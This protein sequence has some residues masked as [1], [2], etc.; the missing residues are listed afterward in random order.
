MTYSYRTLTRGDDEF[1]DA[2][3]TYWNDE[4]VEA[5]KPFNVKKFGFDRIDSE[6]KY[7]ALL[8]QL[9]QV[10][11]GAGICVAGA[12]IL[13]VASGSCWLEAKWLRSEA[14]QKLVC[15]D[16]SVHRIHELAPATMAHYG[17]AGDISLCSGSIFDIENEGGEE[18]DIILMGQAFHH[19]EEPIRL[20]RMLSKLLSSSGVVV[21]VGEHYF[22][23]A[24]YFRCACKH[25]VKYFLN[26]KG[27]RAL[28]TV[29][30]GWQDLFPPDYEKGDI[31]WSLSEYDFLFRKADFTNYSHGVDPTR[32]FQS[33]VLRKTIVKT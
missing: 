11:A 5:S 10:V 33:F 20:L 18:F 30:P 22:G 3:Q 12:R 17:L 13:S 28:H 7:V 8:D 9:Q 26:W 31:H 2:S 27:Y 23:R 14:F 16:V 29:F 1:R 32:R 19:I 25:F 15:I 6:S 21:L 24:A 4:R